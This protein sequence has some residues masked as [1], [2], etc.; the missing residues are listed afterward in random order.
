MSAFSDSYVLRVLLAKPMPVRGFDAAASAVAVDEDH[1]IWASPA[2]NGEESA[3][4]VLG[5]RTYSNE[6][7]SH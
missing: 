1:A 4:A 3:H 6:N 5:A 2:R 7:T